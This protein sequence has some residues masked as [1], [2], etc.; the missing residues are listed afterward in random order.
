ME[1]TQT[2]NQPAQPFSN[3]VQDPTPTP[4]PGVP[5]SGSPMVLPSGIDMLKQSWDIFTKHIH[6]F[7]ILSG[8]VAVL[9]IVM[10]IVMP[11][12]DSIGMAG[13]VN[14][15]LIGMVV[16]LVTII[17]SLIVNTMMTI[18]SLKRDQTWTLGAL[19]EATLPKVGGMI[20]VSFLTGLAV[21]LGILVF[22]IPGIYLSVAL[23]LGIYIYLDQGIKGSAALNLS[24]DYVKGYWWPILGRYI[25][26]AIVYVIPVIILFMFVGGNPK[27]SGIANAILTAIL[28]PL[29]VIYCTLVY[30][31]L[32]KI[33]TGV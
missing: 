30:E 1:E 26:F 22:V 16:A 4:T 3:P 2:S 33:K 23:S 29:G 11:N 19:W 21:L 14:Q 9:Q 15:V 27:A 7:A 24:R 8:L 13:N 31:A 12:E 17:V 6:T 32:K 25:I 28:T 10:T 5:V 18:F 20:W